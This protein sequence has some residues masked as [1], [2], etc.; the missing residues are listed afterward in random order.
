LII[1]HQGV[2]PEI[3]FIQATLKGHIYVPVCDNNN[4]TREFEREQGMG[5]REEKEG[6]M[7]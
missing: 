7:M 2:I 4:W 1:Q 3:T 6:K 5:F